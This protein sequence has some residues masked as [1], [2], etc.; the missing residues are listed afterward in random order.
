MTETCEPVALA[1]DPDVI[2]TERVN[3]LVREITGD[4]HAD[5]LVFVGGRLAAVLEGGPVSRCGSETPV[6]SCGSLR[7]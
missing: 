1:G 7:G 6:A 4:P 5:T 3:R 2:L